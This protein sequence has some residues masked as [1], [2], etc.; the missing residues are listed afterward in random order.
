GVD[1]FAVLGH[2][3]GGPNA[4]ACARFLGDRLVGC[5]AVSSPAPP[6]AKVSEQG[7]FWFNRVL[8][9]VAP[10]APW[11]LTLVFSWERVLR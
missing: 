10:V 2:S 11:F 4:V 7:K 8:Q 3:S 5:A 6:Q 1:R 9:R